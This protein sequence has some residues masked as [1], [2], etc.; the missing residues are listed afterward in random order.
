MKK[1]VLFIVFLS[2]GVYSSGQSLSFAEAVEMLNNGN[3]KLKGMEKQIDA[4]TMGALS[5]KGLR[6]PKLTLN[7]SFVHMKEDLSFDFNGYK[8][9]LTQY[10]PIIAGLNL[11]IDLSSLAQ[12]DWRYTF[13]DQDIGRLS[14]DF[15][16]AIFTGGK[17]N[18]G[19]RAAKIKSEIAK[20]EA[21]ETQNI[22]IA[23]LAERYFQ[24]QLA[25]EA[26]GVREQVLASAK[27][28]LYNAKKMEE[29]G[30]IAPV[31]TMQAQTAVSDAERDLKAAQKDKE[32]AN[33]ALLGLMGKSNE[34][35]DLTTSL[36]AINELKEVKYYQDLAKE[37]YPE[38]VKAK[39]QKQLAEQNVAAHKGNFMP[40]VALIGKKYLL[41]ENIPL[42]EPDDWYVGVGVKAN[43]FNGLQNKRDYKQAVAISESVDLLKAQ[44]EIDIQTL[45]QKYYTEI[46]KQQEQLES[47]NKS[48]AFSEELVRV[49]EKAFKN[50]FAT[51]TDVSDANLYLSSIKIKRLKAMFE[52][53]KTLAKL[54]ETC[55]MSNTFTDYTLLN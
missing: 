19:I 30:M 13:Q 15:E 27:N 21:D 11:P 53:D 44:A 4:A 26:I 50:G 39:Y 18:A 20:V 16:W 47:L 55:G 3:L 38:I 42:T 52:M 28:H 46:L 12:M 23:T 37:N 32:L 5:A 54:L 10:A 33:V 35:F 49:R 6:Y 2:F 25:K 1:L 9:Y 22:L 43:V 48:V 17:I 24:V 34:K 7:G 14:L 29:N 8:S 36:F 41:T 51:S 31:E 45:V 40:D